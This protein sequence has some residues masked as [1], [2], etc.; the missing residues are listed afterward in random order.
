M[1]ELYEAYS[2]LEDIMALVEQLIAALAQELYGAPA[3]PHGEGTID[4]TPPWRRL[5]MLQGIQEYAGVSP[6]AFTSFE[7]A[8]AAGARLGLDMSRETHTGGIIEKIHERFVQPQLIAPTFIT[9]FPTET[10]PL[11][12][13][14]PGS[15]SVVRRFEGYLAAQEICNA[16]SEINDPDDQR[17]RFLQQAQLAARGDEEAHPMDEDFLRALEYGMP[18]TG[19]LGIGIDRL[20]MVLTDTDSIRDVILFPQMKPET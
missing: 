14:N 11:A 3:I 5:P 10:S 8:K 15:P 16:F 17:E 13:K 1:L 6:E 18:P 12:K 2:N 7:E 9:D 19:G 4:V 20:V